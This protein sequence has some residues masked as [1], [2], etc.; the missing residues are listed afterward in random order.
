MLRIPKREK[1]LS[2]S[3][4]LRIVV[5][6]GEISFERRMETIF[7]AWLFSILLVFS[8]WWVSEIRWI[9]QLYP[10]LQS[11]FLG[12]SQ[13]KARQWTIWTSTEK[14]TREMDQD[15]EPMTIWLS[16]REIPGSPMFMLVHRRAICNWK[17]V[18]G[19]SP[20]CLIKLFTTTLNT[21]SRISS[22]SANGQN[23]F[24]LL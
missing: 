9:S 18:W 20:P 17:K 14:E 21:F 19:E 22:S 2:R 13:W 4:I 23:T 1:G 16:P 8:Q 5:L 12:A 6:I 15:H 3:D 7:N 24:W 11:T 10:Q